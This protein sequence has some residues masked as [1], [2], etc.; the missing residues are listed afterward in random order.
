M[1]CRLPE[2]QLELTGRCQAQARGRGGR[3][4]WTGWDVQEPDI[5][6]A[7]DEHR[8]GAVDFEC[9]KGGSDRGYSTG[10]LVAEVVGCLLGCL[11]LL[12][13]RLCGLSM[14]RRV[15]D[16]QAHPEPATARRAS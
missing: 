4:V 5:E 7:A 2:A 12:F 1:L 13:A 16:K 9:E 8:R 11:V 3:V 10:Q 6:R 15:G 14:G